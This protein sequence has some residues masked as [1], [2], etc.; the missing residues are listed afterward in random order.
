MDIFD[1]LPLPV[2]SARFL[3][4]APVDIGPRAAPGP[5]PN[6]ERGIVPIIGGVFRGR[7]GMER[8]HGTVLP[9]HRA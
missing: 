6:S 9:A 2:L 7:P 4:E 1:R 5:G 3:W 8:F